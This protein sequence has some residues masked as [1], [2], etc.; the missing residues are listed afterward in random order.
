MFNEVKENSP[1]DVRTHVRERYGKIASDFH[2]E[3]AAN[4]FSPPENPQECR[5][6][7]H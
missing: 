1:V 2:P 6:G 7:E 5:F 3:I 4:C